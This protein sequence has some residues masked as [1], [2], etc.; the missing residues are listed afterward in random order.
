LTP[1]LVNAILEEKTD[2]QSAW[3][4]AL[5]SLMTP[6]P[7]HKTTVVAGVI[8]KKGIKS[9]SGTMLQK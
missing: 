4:V 7:P 8:K 3:K 1:H 2:V 9:R 6:S 5:V